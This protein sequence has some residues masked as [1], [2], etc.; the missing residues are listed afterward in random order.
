MLHIL[1]LI[2]KIIGI[3]LAVIL[4]ILVLLVCV[5]LFVPLRYQGKARCEGALDTLYIAAKATWLFKLIQIYYKYENQKANYS[6][7]IG[8]KR[9][10]GGQTY[11]KEETKETAKSQENETSV[12]DAEKILQKE[13]PE[14]NQ[15]KEQETLQKVCE[16]NEKELSSE[17]AKTI[18]SEDEDISKNTGASGKGKDSFFQKVKHFIIGWKKK[19]TDIRSKIKCTFTNICD[20]IKSLSTKKD[21][22]VSFLQD[23][24]HKLA[25]GKV[26]KEIWKLLKRLKPQKKL[27]EV[28]FGFEDPSVTGNVL[29]GLAVL[30][31][32]FGEDASITPDFEQKVLEGRLMVKGRM[33]AVHFVCMIWNLVWYKPVRKSYKDIRAFK[34]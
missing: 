9:I 32:F 16:N 31:P 10:A 14:K 25:F 1:F 11:V 28:R 34:W 6:I 23:A 8:W 26:K 2:L 24:D 17:T 7:R 4:G 3:I 5:V 22:I 13:E 21:M 33:Y 29:A 19:L 12:K 30:Y 18:S 27:L 20:K 15:E